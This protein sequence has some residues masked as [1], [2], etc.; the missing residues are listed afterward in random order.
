MKKAYDAII[1]GAGPGGCSAATC[2]ACKGYDVLL[3]DKASFPR[4]K[5][6]GDGISPGALEVL[7]R[8]GVTQ[9]IMDRSPWRIDGVEISSPAGQRVR[10]NFSHLKGSYKHGWVMPRREFD[11]LLFQHVQS[12]PNVH[13]LENC[14]VKD[15]SYAGSRIE[16]VQVKCGNFMEEFSGKVIIGADG[17]YSLV[18]QKILFPGAISRSHAFAVRAYFNHVQRLNHYIEIHCEESIL[19]AY[20]WIFPTGEDSANVGVGISCRFLKKKDIKKLFQAFIGKNKFLKEKLCNAQFIENSFKGWP[21]PLGIF[22][23]RRSHK[24]VLLIGDAG[25]FADFLTGE[26]IY[27]ALRGGE[28]AAEAVHIG[29]HIPGGLVR[30]GEVYE[31]LW[32]RAFQSREYL[33]AKILPRFVISKK[34]LNFNVRRALEK[35]VMAQTLASILCHQ[36]TKIRL[37]F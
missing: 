1:V 3:V 27:Y 36:K 25:C 6:C 4:D 34:F 15:L 28:C 17:V 32:R 23:P 10:A 13:V 14:E 20:G 9:K 2:L 12:F 29:L 31:K 22:S 18:A 5:V 30:M 7:D 8:L 11:F 26:G 37:L 35:S 33:I 16:G 21:I 19:P 24:N